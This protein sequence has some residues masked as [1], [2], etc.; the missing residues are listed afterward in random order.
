M[1]KSAISGLFLTIIFATLSA[2][3]Y[4]RPYEYSV[5][6][7]PVSTTYFNFDITDS[8]FFDPTA[9]HE[10]IY[11]DRTETNWN[12]ADMSPLYQA[13]SAMTYGGF[14]T[15]QPPAGIMEW[16][17]RSEN[18]TAVVSQSPKNSTA[19]FPVP[20][21]LMA[22]LG[23]DA[24]G[25][26]EN[27][28]GNNLDITH[29]YASY[30]DNRLYFRL[31]NR[32]GGFPTS[33]GLLTYYIYS[34]GLINPNA[35]DSTAYVLMYANAIL[36]TTGL[37]ALD[38]TDSSFTQIGS[39]TTN[40]SGNSLSL[41]CNI[42]DL[43]AQPGWPTW[44][45]E[46]G[47][48][49]AAPVTVTANL[50]GLTTNDMGKS[51]IYI[52]SSRQLDFTAANSAPSIFGSTV[53]CDDTGLVTAE[54]TYS[55]PENNLPVIRNL[56]FES[57]PHNLFACEK[58][59][60]AGALF[61]ISFAATESRWYRYY[62]E[63]CDGVDTVN[64]PLDSLYIDLTTFICGDVNGDLAVNIL[65]IVYLIDYKFKGGPAPE[66]MESA[67]VNND[68]SVNILDIVYLI[69]YKFKGGPEPSCP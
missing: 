43:T 33:G 1:I 18:D 68:G 45:P 51:A 31:D 28:G 53:A 47:F 8:L 9:V 34:V 64:T 5:S 19:L 66:I 17:F 35:T 25:D 13:C 46:A 7:A 69:D 11:R 2:Q 16:Y 26:V 54:I 6:S 22:D 65:D 15:Y 56:Y 21:Y 62:F 52:P 44:P 14:V 67:D 20:Q 63:F 59:Y 23:G 37:Y 29:F 42:S 27:G 58:D 49:G 12:R 50:S 38:I 41:S 39:V 40:I 55:D 48:V 10:L 61:G 24:T 30:S 4:P 32:S 60:Q 3:D 57:V 36:Y